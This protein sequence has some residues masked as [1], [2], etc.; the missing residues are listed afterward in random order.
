MKKIQFV[1]F[2]LLL[3]TTSILIGQE[4]VKSTTP[5]TLSLNQGR[6]W[7]TDNDVSAN[8]TQV[9]LKLTLCDLYPKLCPTFTAKWWRIPEKLDLLA[10]PPII[11][12]PWPFPL[13]PTDPWEKFD[14]CLLEYG[15][16]NIYTF[17]FG[18]QSDISNKL[19][20]GVSAGIGFETV[21]RNTSSINDSNFTITNMSNPVFNYGAEL[22]YA[23]SKRFSVNMNAG[24]LNSYWGDISILA[25]D[26]SSIVIEGTTLKSPNLSFGVSVGL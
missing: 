6:I 16:S 26:G 11:I 14:F 13:P 3:S 24:M 15:S 7:Y 22:S 19:V 8:I 25:D 17:D 21:S 20:L 4:E 10:P 2:L 23:I 5:L 12:R 9:K 18:L 1:V